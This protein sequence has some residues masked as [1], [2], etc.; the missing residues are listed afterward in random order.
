MIMLSFEKKSIDLVSWGTHF[1]PDIAATKAMFE[2]FERVTLKASFPEQYESLGLLKRKSHVTDIKKRY[3]ESNNYLPTHSNGL[4]L[5]T[6]KKVALGKSLSEL[7]ERHTIMK[8]LA[9]GIRGE[10]IS[11][12]GKFDNSKYS[13]SIKYLRFYGALGRIIYIASYCVSKNSFLFGFGCSKNNDE[14]MAS[15]YLELLPNIIWYRENRSEQILSLEKSIGLDK[16]ADKSFLDGTTGVVH[17]D[18]DIKIKHFYKAEIDLDL[19]DDLIGKIQ[20]CRVFSPKLQ[21]RILGEWC[22]TKL[23]PVAIKNNIYKNQYHI[24]G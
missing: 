5:H 22:A 6:N 21:Q 12:Q 17:I 19:P 15:A 23:N 4:A 3:T 8:V 7:I 11:N 13:D 16:L 14:A 10:S 24:I 1:E 18:T 20:G 9:H 2:L